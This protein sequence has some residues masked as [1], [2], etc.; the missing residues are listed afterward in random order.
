MTQQSYSYQRAPC[1]PSS[2]QAEAARV[3]AV[4]WV[5][6]TFGDLAVP[7]MMISSL[8]REVCSVVGVAA[9]PRQ[10]VVGAKIWR[11]PTRRSLCLELDNTTGSSPPASLIIFAAPRQPHTTPRTPEQAA[12]MSRRYDS[13]VSP[14]SDVC[15]Q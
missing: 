8:Y 1:A 3:P 13:R 9:L 12:I 10:K 14:M 4:A 5:S 6:Q 11:S 2:L 15:L 7:D